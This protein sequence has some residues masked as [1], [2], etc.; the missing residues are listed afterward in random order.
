[1]IV[2]QIGDNNELSLIKKMHFDFFLVY[3]YKKVI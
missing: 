1:M 2:I 3:A